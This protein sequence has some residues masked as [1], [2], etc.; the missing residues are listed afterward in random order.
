MMKS[1]LP[2]IRIA[3][4]L[5]V[6][7]LHMGKFLSSTTSIIVLV[8]QNNYEI[9]ALSWAAVEQSNKADDMFS[10]PFSQAESST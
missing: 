7:N 5:S 8:V 3:Q 6:M 4:A 9:M 10:T 2:W 1:R